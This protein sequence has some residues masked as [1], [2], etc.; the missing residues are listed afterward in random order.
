MCH[1]SAILPEHSSAFQTQSIRVGSSASATW[2]RLEP[3]D[4]CHYCSKHAAFQTQ[5]AR[6]GNSASTT[7]TRLEPED[8]CHYC[9]KHAAFQ[10]QSARVGNSAST[11]WTRLEPEVC[12]HYRSK[13]V[14]CLLHFL[15]TA[16]YSRPK[17]QGLATLHLRPGQ[18]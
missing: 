14:I 17:A 12:C 3:E 13:H 18:D 10:T 7:W 11:T 15:I 2:T 8:W 1:L 5:S 9:S 6:V 16:L 4:W